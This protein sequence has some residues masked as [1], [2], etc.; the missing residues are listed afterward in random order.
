MLDTWDFI[1]YLWWA[2][3][4]TL[5][6][7]VLDKAEMYAISIIW[8]IE[9]K[10]YVEVYNWNW[11]N[12]LV[13]N[14]SPINTITILKFNWETQDINNFYLNKWA[15]IL[16]S[17][18]YFPR[19]FNAIEVEYNA[20]WTNETIPNKLKNAIFSLASKYYKAWDSLDDNVSS[21]SI[22]WASVSWKAVDKTWEDEIFKS[23]R[24]IYV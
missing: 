22:D 3:D 4:I 18:T 2:D 16:S 8:N 1:N 19:G 15:W 5:A 10:N 12:S 11:Q 17:Y 13:L 20:W 7:T 14:N 24:K 23:Y 21:E 9:A 6:Q